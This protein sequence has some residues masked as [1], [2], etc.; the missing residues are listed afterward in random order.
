MQLMRGI[1]ES[2]KQDKFPEFLNNFM[3]QM[4]P[5]N[6]YPSWVVDALKSVNVELQSDPINGV[7]KEETS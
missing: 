6:N 2:I 4:Y 7:K 3:S 1:R 5:S